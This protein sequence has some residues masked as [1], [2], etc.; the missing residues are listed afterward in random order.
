MH[1]DS[2]ERSAC[3]VREAEK[4]FHFN[5]CISAAP[6]HLEKARKNRNSANTQRCDLGRTLVADAFD[7]L[8]SSKPADAAAYDV[9][10]IAIM[11]LHLRRVD[12]I[13]SFS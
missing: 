1:A 6:R 8:T 11:L 4:H 13:G 9:G 5:T 3:V 10:S 2:V 12:P 7:L